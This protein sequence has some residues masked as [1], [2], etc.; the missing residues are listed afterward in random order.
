MWIKDILNMLRNTY[1]L[2]KISRMGGKGIKR[3]YIA[4]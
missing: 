2:N 1:K 4:S 3:L